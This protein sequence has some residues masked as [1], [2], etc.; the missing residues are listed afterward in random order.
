MC[1]CLT[2]LT[3]QSIQ[4]LAKQNPGAVISKADG[5]LQV[6]IMFEGP[7][8]TFTDFEY[9]IQNKKKDGAPHKP[10]TKKTTILHTFC[11]FCG[12]KY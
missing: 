5:M 9:T 3:E 12:N 7:S 1:K 10:R 11:P 2:S 8:R 4:L 6:A